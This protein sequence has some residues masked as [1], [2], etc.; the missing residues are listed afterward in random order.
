[1]EKAINGN[2]KYLIHDFMVSELKLSGTE[3]ITFAIIY[4][5]SKGERGCYFGTHAYLGR[6]GGM[7]L[8]SVK[9][10]LKK[11]LD[12]GYIEKYSYIRDAYRTTSKGEAKAVEVNE[13]NPDIDEEDIPSPRFFE[14][15]DEP[16][17][18]YMPRPMTIP[19][20][21]YYDFGRHGLVLMTAEQYYN[22]LK[23]VDQDMLQCYILR[24][25]NLMRNKLYRTFSPYKTIK[26]WIC[27]DSRV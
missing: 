24:L 1:M 21:R 11:L 12:K 10:S 22:L 3:L 26:K 23:L 20:Y 15:S 5:Y 18:A 19:K 2:T 14:T 8:S 9:R 27:E 16:P 4:S 13:K 25:E 6:I 7:S 17:Q